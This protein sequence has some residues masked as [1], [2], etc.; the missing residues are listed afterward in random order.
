VHEWADPQAVAVELRAQVARALAAGIDATHVD[1]H[2]GTVLAPQFVQSYIDVAQEHQLPLLFLGRDAAERIYGST[3]ETAYFAPI[4]QD[5]EARG[6]ALFDDI[7]MLPLDDPTDH[8]AVMKRSVDNLQPGLTM[9]ILHPAQDTPELRA[10]APD[11][12]S[13]VANYQA[14][15][16]EEL[17]D[18]V[19]QAGV[20]LIGYRPLREALR[21]SR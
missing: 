2:M 15:L 18:Y 14:C 8:V 5:L 3:E 1:A 13:R 6:V 7:G 21:A 9:L 12:S 10:I 19:R 16:S 20:Q 11:W 17:R 4:W